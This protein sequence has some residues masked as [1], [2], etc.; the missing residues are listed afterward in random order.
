MYELPNENLYPKD[1]KV[2]NLIV[3]LQHNYGRL[4]IF[5]RTTSRTKLLFFP[6]TM[7]ID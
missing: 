7:G 2:K 3:S 4:E 5:S 1:Q 6:Q